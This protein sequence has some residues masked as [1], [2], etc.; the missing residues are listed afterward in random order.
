[1]NR[2]LLNRE[3]LA[4]NVRRLDQW[5][6]NHG[7]SWTLVTKV[8]C[9]EGSLFARLADL[10]VDSFGDSRLENLET[11]R[12]RVPNAEVWYLRPPHLSAVKDVVALAD[13]SL[14]T[15]TE[16]INALNDEAVK[17][18]KVH[19]ILIMVETGDLREG[20]LPLDLVEF[21]EG[22]FK[23]SNIQVIGIGSNVGCLYGT[24]PTIDQ[25][26]Q[27]EMYR[28]L[29][30]L[31]FGR[32]LPILSAGTSAVLPLMVEGALPESVNHFRV[33]ESVFLGTD[34]IRGGILPSLRDDVFILEGEVT[35]LQEKPLTPMGEQSDLSP[36]DNDDGPTFAPGQR[37]YR[38]VITMG[39]LDTDVNALVPLNPN[40]SIAGAASDLTVL[41]IGDDDGGLR[42]GD[43]IRFK[44]GYSA[45]L[46]VMSNRYVKREG[47]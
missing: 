37:G 22:V 26:G 1:M 9:G 45:L 13:V 24:L 18:E 17:Q 47:F 21:Y 12:Q 6:K 27:L 34:L 8:L 39:N 25:F 29:L 4:N 40:Y 23:L 5:I 41:N 31:K 33:G 15:E 32:K 43:T 44:L 46:R 38:A 19:K 14:N 10:G 2:L 3:A 16:V 35:E 20:I 28:E 7:A 42:I 11:L 30:E 36:F